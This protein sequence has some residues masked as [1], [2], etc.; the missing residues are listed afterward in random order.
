MSKSITQPA[1]GAILHP[2][3]AKTIAAMAYLWGWPMVNMIN[4]RTAITKAPTPGKLNGVLPC[5]PRGQLGMLNDYID[6]GQMFIACPNQDVVYGLG[7]FALD[8]E[9]VVIQVPDF[10]DRFWVYALYDART[11]QFAARH[12]DVAFARPTFGA[13]HTPQFGLRNPIDRQLIA[14][15]GHIVEVCLAGS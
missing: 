13:E 5:A 9:P 4:R 14:R 1:T 6:P 7:F 15:V 8:E 10:G 3:Y 11:D 12:D 2:D